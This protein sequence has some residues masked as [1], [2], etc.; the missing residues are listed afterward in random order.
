LSV[1]T[2]S[3][4]ILSSLST[5]SYA[6]GGYGPGEPG[7]PGVPG[8]F[9]R[10]VRIVKTIG[11]S[12]GQLST[13]LANKVGIKLTVPPA[14]FVSLVQVAVTAPPFS[15][16]SSMLP[17]LGFR[18]YSPVTG[19]GLFFS[20]PNNGKPLKGN[21]AKPVTVVLRGPDL[22]VPGEKVL[23]LT[24]ATSAEVLATVLS[25]GTATFSLQSDPDLLVVNPINH[26]GR[27]VNHRGR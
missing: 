12:G 9:E 27:P 26:R 19:F 10:D 17:K 14:A 20:N 6:A 2:L 23:E 5:P 11:L 8:G 25:K 1:V 7:L 18:A 3:L 24:S 21:F 16:L 22:G 13:T 4:V 15:E